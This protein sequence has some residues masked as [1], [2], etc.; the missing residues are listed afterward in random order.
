MRACIGTAAACRNVLRFFSMAAI[1]VILAGCAS[2][3]AEKRA[4]GV[5][6]PFEEYNRAVFEFNDSIDQVTFRPL[7]KGYRAA[8]PRPARKGVRNFLRNLRAPIDITNQILQGDL[9]GA[10]NAITRTVVNTLAG[11]GGLIDVAAHEGIPYEP[12]D[13][14]Q[15]L[16][17]WGVAEGPYLVLPLYGP[18]TLRTHFGTMVDTL[19]DPV[20]MWLFNTDQEEWYYARAGVG[21]LDTRESFL[22]VLDQL[23]DSSIDYYAT[24]RSTIHQRQQALIHDNDPDYAGYGGHDDIP[25]YGDFE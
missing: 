5:Y 3:G 24:L 9:A 21:I 13:F 14:G 7:A 18:A 2:S 11:F 20:R 22:D 23:R 17:V 6:D 25:D 10:G 4:G 12:E 15:T 19:A 16:A 8:V 1:C